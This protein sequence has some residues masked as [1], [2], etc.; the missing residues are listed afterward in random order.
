MTISRYNKRRTSELRSTV[1]T[2]WNDA[3]LSG[4]ELQLTEKVIRGAAQPTKSSKVQRCT[5]L[6]CGNLSDFP[7]Q[8]CTLIA[9]V[10]GRGVVAKMF[11]HDQ[12]HYLT[13]KRLGHVDS[14]YV[15]PFVKDVLT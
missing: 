12:A 14:Y 9:L 6:G 4:S 5:C 1:S 8:H 2:V 7:L 10:F 13:V 3:S 15:S 11:I